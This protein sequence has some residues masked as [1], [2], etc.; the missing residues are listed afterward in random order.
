MNSLRAST[1]FAAIGFVVCHALFAPSHVPCQATDPGRIAKGDRLFVA[2]ADTPFWQ[3]R[4]VAWRLDAN[5][6][7]T[8]LGVRDA[9][10]AV[11]LVTRG[12]EQFGWMRSIQLVKPDDPEALRTLSEINDDLATKHR[13]PFRIEKNFVNQVMR[14]DA[15]ESDMPPAALAHLAGLYSLEGLELGGTKVADGDMKHLAAL[16]NLRWI[17]LDDTEISDKGLVHFKALTNLDVVTLKGTRVTGPGL[18]N[19][20]GMTKLRALNLSDCRVDDQSLRHIAGLT[21]IETIAL[22]NTRVRGPGLAHLKRLRRL[23]VL[24]LNKTTIE[25]D[26]LLHLLGAQRLRILHM[27]NTLCSDDTKDVLRKSVPALQIYDR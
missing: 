16:T 22:Q 20:A 11:S 10:V 4:Q 5:T 18:A 25:G 15:S 14:I 17:Y 3:D 12:E 1:A 26:Y 2:V 7:V 27:K 24:N 6:E 8:A 9:W 19:L 13:R 21:H 23:N